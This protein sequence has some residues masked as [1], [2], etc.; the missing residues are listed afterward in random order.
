[1]FK[2]ISILP[3]VMETQTGLTGLD[4]GA[5]ELHKGR[6][7]DAI[8]EGY[9]SLHKEEQIKKL[10]KI[11]SDLPA[12]LIP[13]PSE[14]LLDVGCGSGISTAPWDCRCTGID[15]SI[16]LIKIAQKNYPGKDF[17]VGHAENLPFKEK[18]FDFVISITAIHNFSDI[19]KGILEMKRVGRKGFV[20]TVLRK[21]SN[22]DL[23]Q[24]LLIIN[25]RVHKIVMED[26]DIIF[27]C[28]GLV[29]GKS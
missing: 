13:K 23:I 4:K 19:K 24:K 7:Y 25:F 22:V 27:I 6:Y 11:L 17:I 2:N 3:Y 14:S 18:S 5:E 26:K 28:E 21:S 10:A 15:P 20:F 16:E 29:K 1:M 9:D 12:H 8:A